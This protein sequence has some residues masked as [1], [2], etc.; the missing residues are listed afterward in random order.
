ML[1]QSAVHLP[2]LP[3]SS[4]R[5]G[6]FCRELCMRVHFGERHMAEYEAEIGLAPLCLTFAGFPSDRLGPL[7]LSGVKVLA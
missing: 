1:V 3:L 4:G 7:V 5:F 2:E 6:G